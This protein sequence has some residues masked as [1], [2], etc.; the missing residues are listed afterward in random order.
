MFKE[1]PLPLRR[2]TAAQ[3]FI[4]SPAVTVEQRKYYK[5]IVVG[6]VIQVSNCLYTTY[7]KSTGL[8]DAVMLMHTN[9]STAVQSAPIVQVPNISYKHVF[10][11]T[12]SD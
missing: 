12:G 10:N 7:N 6:L 5:T 3:Y 4:I 2:A 11:T 8:F 1:T 9:Y